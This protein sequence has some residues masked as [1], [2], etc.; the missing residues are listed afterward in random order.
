MCFVPFKF[1]KLLV[2][3]GAFKLRGSTMGQPLEV[4][5]VEN[6]DDRRSGIVIGGAVRDGLIA[7][8]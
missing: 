3:H 8:V 6:P 7:I 2:S 1:Q 4:E 5:H